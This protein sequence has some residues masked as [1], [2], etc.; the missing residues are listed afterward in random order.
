MS[1]NFL[2]IFSD[3]ETDSFRGNKILQIAA[4]T[5]ANE[6][7]NVFIDPQGPLQSST[8]NF[9]G[10]HYFKGSLWRNG[11]KLNTVSVSQALSDFMKWIGERKQP[12]ILIFHNGYN[13][14]CNILTRHLVDHGISIPSNLVKVGDT[15]PFFRDTIKI[16]LIENHKLSSLAEYFKIKQGLAHCALSDSI[17][18]K[19]ICEAYIKE[20]NKKLQEIFLDR[21]RD[22][23][24]YLDKKIHNTP[25]PKLSKKRP[26][27]DEGNKSME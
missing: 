1:D 19:H 24:L 27:L 3:I 13:F 8:S 23:K 14:D 18:L 5:E 17:T 2:H 16:P 15:L 11:S 7:F 10:L 9:L 4:I 22:I 12:V 25:I 6:I 26:M 21:T 20:S